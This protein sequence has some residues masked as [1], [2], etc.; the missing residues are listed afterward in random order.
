M[1]IA[2]SV[3]LLGRCGVVCMRGMQEVQL[4]AAVAVHAEDSLGVEGLTMSRIYK[5]A[6]IFVSSS[7]YSGQYYSFEGLA[8]NY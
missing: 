6:G 2:T 7:E 1:G 8:I 3:R 5:K 4:T